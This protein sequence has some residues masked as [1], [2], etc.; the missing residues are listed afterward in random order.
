[1]IWQLIYRTTNALRGWT[2]IGRRLTKEEIDKNFGDLEERVWELEENPPSAVGVSNITQPT[3]NTFLVW[4]ADGSSFGPFTLPMTRL[5]F[6]EDG[7]LPSTGY[8]AGEMFVYER[9]GFYLVLQDHVSAATFVAD[10]AD[11]EGNF[12]RLLFNPFSGSSTKELE[13]NTE[14]TYDPV[15]TDANKYL[16]W[17][18]ADDI[19]ITI[20]TDDAVPFEIDT[21]LE[22]RQAGLGAI[23]I[24]G[25]F[26]VIVNPPRPNFST[27]TPW[28]GATC[29][30][31]KIDANA[32]DYAGVGTEGTA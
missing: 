15:L 27:R 14:L 8:F 28:Q 6:R 29:V 5:R 19:L 26:G 1:M 30:V 4:L 9:S 22:F 23:I 13:E 32:W 17:D 25:D 3:D 10:A 31:K 21:I 20:P 11:T 24:E 12:Y 2:G 16:R 18:N 7:W